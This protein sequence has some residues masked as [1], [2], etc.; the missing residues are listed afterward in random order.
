LDDIATWLGTA[1]A[2]NIKLAGILYLHRVTDT[3]VG[4]VASSNLRMFKKLCGP[5]FYPRVTLVSTMWDIVDRETA[6]GREAELKAKDTFWGHMIDGGSKVRRHW[7]DRDSAM[8]ILR[9]MIGNRSKVDA[10]THLKVQTEMVEEKLSINETSAGQELLSK[11]LEERKRYERMLEA[12]KREMQECLEERDMKAA[13]ESKRAQEMLEAKLRQGY[14]DQQKL[15]VK[16]E[17]MVQQHRLQFEEMERKEIMLRKELEAAKVDLEKKQ[18][19]LKH[20]S[21]DSPQALVLRQQI[22][23][24]EDQTKKV[25]EGLAEQE[26]IVRTEKKSK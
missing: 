17:E 15:N 22:A 4:G 8:D 23:D 1:Y 9:E 26:E 10:P 16:F 14:E 7:N 20:L 3:R 11:I 5:D 19:R 13:D 25:S 18:E 12:A 21:A 2:F 24:A 6:E